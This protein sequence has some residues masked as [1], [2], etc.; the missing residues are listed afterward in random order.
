MSSGGCPLSPTLHDTPLE[1]DSAKFVCQRPD[2]ECFRVSSHGLCR[3]YSTLRES[4]E[5]AAEE[6]QDIPP[7]NGPLGPE[8]YFKLV[9]FET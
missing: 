6:E 8:D 7:Q 4:R 3:N 2:S 1:Q 5:N 9:I